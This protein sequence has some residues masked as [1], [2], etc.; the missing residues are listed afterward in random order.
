MQELWINNRQY[1]NLSNLFLLQNLHWMPIT[2]SN[3]TQQRVSW[4]QLGLHPGQQW[5]SILHILWSHVVVPFS[6]R[7]LSLFP[8]QISSRSTVSMWVLSKW[9]CLQE[10]VERHY[11]VSYW[12][13]HTCPGEKTRTSDD[14]ACQSQ[15]SEHC[16]MLHSNNLHMHRCIICI[17]K[18]L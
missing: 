10:C 5:L 14:S 8:L 11:G 4:W 2:I 12:T 9:I 16:V 18:P 3:E 17:G 7:K 15:W 13:S 1:G 6:L